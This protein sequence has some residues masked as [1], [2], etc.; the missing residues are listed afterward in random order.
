ME[1][2]EEGNKLVSIW[3]PDI[4]FAGYK[5]ILHGGI[6]SALMDEIAGWYVSAIMKKRGMTCNL[7]VRYKKPAKVDEG[8]LKLVASF[9]NTQRNIVSIK[10]DLFNSSEELCSTG[11]VKYFL[12]TATSEL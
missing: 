7:E 2:F 5:N 4:N 10:T 8:N 12:F 1:F 9:L 11:I 3:K 6:H